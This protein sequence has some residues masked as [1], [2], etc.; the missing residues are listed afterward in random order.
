VLLFICCRP[1]PATLARRVRLA[2]LGSLLY[3]LPPH[4]VLPVTRAPTRLPP[5]HRSARA[6]PQALTQILQGLPLARRAMQAPTAPPRVVQRNRTAQL[7]RAERMQRRPARPTA[8]TAPAATT[9]TQALRVVRPWW[10]SR[11]RRHLP[12]RAATLATTST[13]PIARLAE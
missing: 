7:A 8:T 1:S 10:G 5:G 4:H 13:A 6:V 11:P 12:R 2:R 3:I 9:R